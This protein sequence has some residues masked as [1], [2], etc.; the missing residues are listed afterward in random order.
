[1]FLTIGI[2]FGSIWAYYELGWG[3]WWFWDP[4]ENVSFMP[5]LVA[6]ALLHSAIVVEKRG[7][8]KSW[9]ILL[10]I[11]AFSFSLV[12]AF[13]VRSGILT[14]VH[15]FANDPDRGMFLVLILA[16][17]IGGS[18]TLYAARA[19]PCARPPP[20]P[21]SAARA[22]SSSTTSCSSSPPPSSSSAPCGR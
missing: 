5:W 14:S 13:I 9:T 15:S 12:G 18:L 3:G 6:C 1:M 11:L 10:A 16:A 2:A 20:S 7:T 22:A 17:F 8:L 4:V 21:S 19:G